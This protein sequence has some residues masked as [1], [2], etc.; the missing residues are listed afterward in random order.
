MKQCLFFSQKG[1]IGREP[2]F[3]VRDSAR[4]ELLN[5]MAAK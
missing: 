2:E 5:Y 4:E 1:D 3:Q